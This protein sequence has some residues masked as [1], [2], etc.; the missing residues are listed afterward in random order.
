M[1]KLGQR[2]KDLVSGLEGIATAKV[3]Y[4]NG[5]VQFYVEPPVDRDGKHIKGTYVDVDQLEVVDEG[6]L[7]KQVEPSFGGG[8]V[9]ET[10]PC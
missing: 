8:G 7:P 3:E 10:P 5:C 1:I 6:I 2:V 4:L 9:R